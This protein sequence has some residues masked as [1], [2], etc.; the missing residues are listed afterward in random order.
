MC[1]VIR[2]F[3]RIVRLSN[4]L[5]LIIC[6]SSGA[7]HQSRVTVNISV[8]AETLWKSQLY[9]IYTSVTEI[10]LELELKIIPRQIEKINKD[11]TRE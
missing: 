1:G 10:S 4:H 8:W 3:V 7:L 6:E 5:Y 2:I 11:N 9:C